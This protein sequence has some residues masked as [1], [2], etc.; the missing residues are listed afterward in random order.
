MY[1]NMLSFR[2]FLAV[3]IISISLSSCHKDEESF[4][5]EDTTTFTAKVEEE[6]TGT[7]FGYIYDEANKPVAD[8]TVAIYSTTTKTSS[9]GV[10]IFNNVK[11]DKQ[12]TFIKA[13]KNGFILGSDLVYPSDKASTYSYI[14]MMA[15]EN[16]KSFEAKDGGTIQVT[17]GGTV[18][19]PADAIVKSNGE[20][21]TGKVTTTAKYLNPS[22]PDMDDL[23]PGGLI[24]D[25]ADKRTVVLGTLGM[26]AIEL[27]GSNNEEL[28][29]AEGKKAT[30]NFPVTTSYQP[31]TI[32]LWSFDEAKGRW[33]E[34]GFATKKGNFYVA[35]VGH[36]SFWNCDVPFPLVNLCGKIITSTG[37]AIINVTVKIEVESLNAGWG[38]TN[39]KGEFCGKVPKGKTLKLSV[40]YKGCNGE[41]YNTTIGPFTDN[42]TL[43][44]IIV[45]IPNEQILKGTIVCGSIPINKG[46]VVVEVN[47]R[48]LL[49]KVNENGKFDINLTNIICNQPVNLNVFGIN[50]ETNE[51]SPTSNYTNFAAPITLDVCASGCTFTGNIETD[52]GLNITV[53]ASGGSGQYSYKWDNGILSNTIILGL[54]NDSLEGGLYCVTVTDLVNSCE[55]KFCK[56]VG[57]KLFASEEVNCREK[58]AT[59]YP[60]GGVKPYTYLWSDGINTKERQLTTIGNYAYTVTDKNNCTFTKIITWN[61]GLSISDLPTACSKNIY[62][63][64]SDPFTYG[65]TRTFGPGTKVLFPIQFNIFETGFN[66]SLNLQNDNCRIQKD[67]IL[68]TLREGLNTSPINTTC[69]TCSDGKINISVN[70]QANCIQCT[71]GDTKIFKKSDLNTDL[72]AQNENSALSKGD[73]YV[74]VTDKNTGCYIAFNEVIIK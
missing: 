33:Q 38:V 2:Y 67:I 66:F 49:F 5:S 64:D 60:Y 25:A 56:E 40:Y 68:P 32:A 8:A 44:N 7:I 16:N 18:V 73:Y 59:I 26:V 39:D 46:L 3:A 28:N 30:I 50:T 43:D 6:I 19:F 52:C 21:Y 69:G 65:E 51:T 72:S 42:V 29:L 57:G 10:F 54:N 47:S 27:R 45:N 11:M 55:K 15:L 24:A 70:S 34:E 74:V 53:I 14:K 41:I 12:G 22:N 62:N 36:F 13:S 20:V 4:T 31:E 48:S 37:E 71:V 1:K 23:M 63:F 17:D 35:E 9:K 58:I 61:G